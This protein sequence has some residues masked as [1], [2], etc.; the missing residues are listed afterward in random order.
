VAL[1]YTLA[2]CMFAIPEPHISISSPCQVSCAPLNASVGY[3]ITNDSSEIAQPGNDFCGYK[4]FDDT[5]INRCAT[6]YSFIPQQ[7]FL[8]NCKA[9]PPRGNGPLLTSQKSCRLCTLLVATRRNRANPSFP[10]PIP[11]SMKR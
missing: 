1:R 9:V 4:V 2:G 8:A 10:M 3:Q 6:C 11:S 7:L 5:T